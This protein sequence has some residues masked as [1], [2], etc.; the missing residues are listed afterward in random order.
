MANNVYT[1]D[2]ILDADGKPVLDAMKMV[3]KY[4]GDIQKTISAIGVTTKKDAEA[5]GLQ[6]QQNLKA[7][8]QA[9]SDLR[10]LQTDRQNRVK[11]FEGVEKAERD[12]VKARKAANAEI[13]RDEK[14]R[15]QQR[16]IESRMWYGQE[17]RERKAANKR[18]LQEELEGQRQVADA[19][20][21]QTAQDKADDQARIRSA[22]AVRD[23]KLEA[24]RA[25]VTAR[26]RNL[27]DVEEARQFKAN[28]DAR[29]VQL[30]REREAIASTN[31]EAAR[32]I[33]QRIEIEKALGRQLDQ[34]I[35]K[36]QRQQDAMRGKLAGANN[37]DARLLVPGE[38]GG[39][40]SGNGA[41]NTLAFYRAQQTAAREQLLLTNQNNRATIEQRVAAQQNLELANL[42]VTAARRLVAEEERAAA[43]AARAAA[44][45][46]RAAMA[47]EPRKSPIQNILSPG[48]AGAAFARTSV[49]GGAAMA[50]YGAFNAVTGSITDVVRLE[51]EMAKLQAISNSTDAQMQ[52][53]RASIFDIGSTS[54]YSVTELTQI[55][56]TLAQAGV[57]AAQMDD[58]LK[59]V[60]TLATA[61][62]STPDEA[63]GLVTSALGS[64]QLQASEAARVADL[65][66][67]A[68]NRTKLTVG[69]V[70]QAIQYVGATAFEQNISLE[71]LLA[72]VG[73]VAQAGVRS[74]STIG[75]GFRQFLVDLQSPSEKLT[76][77]LERLGLTQDDVNVKTLG[78]AK[79]LDNLKNAGFNSAQ[80][81]EGLETRAA[82]FYLV[83]KNNT[84]IMEDL[85]I[86]FAQQGAAAL[87]N[88]RAMNSLTAQW[89]R[90]KNVVSQ[91]FADDFD[92]VLTILKNMLR[93]VTD[94]YTKI[95][96]LRKNMPR[97]NTEGGGLVS[98]EAGRAFFRKAINFATL[99][100]PSLGNSNDRGLGDW[101][102]DLDEKLQGAG[103]SA[104]KYGE[105][106]DAASDKINTH[107]ARISEADK[108]IARLVTQQGSLQG[109][110]RAVAAETVTLTSRFEGLVKFLGTTKD[111]YLDLINAMNQYRGE[112]SRFLAQAIEGQVSFQ[113]LQNAD[114]Q[115]KLTGSISSIRGNSTLMGRLT[116]KERAALNNPNDLNFTATMNEAAR[117]LGG[118]ANELTKSLYE[119]GN[120]ASQLSIGNRSVERGNRMAGQA[121]AASTGLGQQ[122]EG[123]IAYNQQQVDALNG[124]TSAE[125][126]RLAGPLRGNINSIIANLEK[127]LPGT[128]GANRTFIQEAITTFRGMLSAIANALKPT[129]DE[130]KQAAKDKREA[131]KAERE[132]AKRPKVTQADLDR[133]ILNAGG[134]LGSGSR[135]PEEQEALYRRGVTPARGYGDRISNHVNSVARDIPTRGMSPADVQRLAATVRAQLQQEGIDARVIIEDG[136]TAGTGPHIHVG[137]RRGA[138][139]GKDRSGQAESRF[140]TS[141]SRDQLELDQAAMKLALESVGQNATDSA[142]AA[143]QDAVEKVNQSLRDNALDELA[144]A[145]VGIGSPGYQAKMAQ[146]EQSIQQN[147]QDFQN[148]LTDAA[149]KAADAAFKAADTAFEAAVRPAQTQ[150]DIANAQSSGLELFSNRNKVPDYVKQL[151]E[152]RIGRANENLLRAQSAAM[153]AQI[154]AK[155]AAYAATAA[156]GGDPVQLAAKLA[157]MN[158]ELERLRANKAALDAQLGAGGLIPQTI[159]EG[160]QQA[161]QAFREANNLGAS[162]T[163]MVNMNLGGG[164][165][166]LDE[167]LTNMFSGI[168]TG[169]QSALG[170]FG[171]F[172]MG[173]M[174]WLSQLAAQMLAKQ[175]LGQL[176]SLIGLGASAS[177]AF[178]PSTGP[179]SGGLPIS[180]TFNGGEIG[181]PS[182]T[183]NR[184]GG[185][186][187][188][189]GSTGQDS[190]RT[191]L[192][193]GE[194]VVRKRAVDSVGNQ[195]MA[196]L[197]KHGGK[198][199]EDLKS[200]PKIEMK[201]RTETNVYV[202]PPEEKPS[203]G[204]NDV[205]VVMRDDMMN[206]EGR[207]LIQHIARDT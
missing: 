207:R 6:L 97:F 79:V 137:V 66:T 25:G 150:L 125:R 122:I 113:S 10:A 82:A 73:A 48:Y 110:S 51:D 155:E 11:G 188:S 120:Y 184:A 166:M 20:R 35:G 98:E 18:I 43:A 58:V 41:A 16:L 91:S 74:G 38:V 116:A 77:Q 84:D 45:Q 99:T 138:R 161:V 54:R 148:K 169:S 12:R 102:L 107:S 145:G 104:Q 50:A 112:E 172:A 130:V 49:Y 196:R 111:G 47:N 162:M 37:K 30:R 115:R 127:R 139:F 182:V 140:A 126:Q 134:R 131:D 53:L 174:N 156:A 87:A 81:Y 206:G 100:D 67:E 78:L 198:A 154:A 14:Q 157:E 132:A 40:A 167:N 175:I 109:N 71:Q 9:Q 103:D 57:S 171:N 64:F 163:E 178:S 128:A 72:T 187:V 101:L 180:S 189:N 186:E 26:A 95:D 165:Q 141:L 29:L 55:S 36:L 3:E 13:D 203:L 83:A 69:Q 52:S 7:L 5:W 85:Q 94:A 135:T 60:T 28:S 114:T 22:R 200:S 33:A 192:A 142:I 65:M 34:T 119:A 199:L 1:Q 179:I 129:E 21:R 42:R 197:N 32:G 152:N 205:L 164:I 46:S 194:W 146:V 27:T 44:A 149:I 2:V 39:M 183:I 173:V 124:K 147:Y 117:R 19:A 204:P 144:Q 159:G 123:N 153:P 190:V 23:A 168:I 151:A 170:A 59:S 118:A 8:R 92:G 158:V 133:L 4:L 176:F 86:S 31:S 160:A 193:R 56:Q 185:G 15:G 96:Q 181:H 80:A 177:G 62:G 63:V 24:S 195:F 121:R 76:K 201:S 105:Q 143:A 136:K 70:G 68:L 75:T 93:E 17:E 88:E 191:N 61:S 106:I 108:E 89:Q 202:V 90:F